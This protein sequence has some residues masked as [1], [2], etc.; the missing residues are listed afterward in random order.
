MWS[1]DITKLKGP[2]KW[3]YFYLYVILDIFS[4]YAVGWMVATKESAA[5]A[6]Q[7]IKE[8]VLKQGVA[9]G[10]LTIHSDRGSPMKAK[11]TALLMAD[12]G[13]TKSHS[14][15]YVSDDNPFSESQF[16]TVKYNPD[17]PGCFG[18]V[19]DARV[20]CGP[21]F[22][23]YNTEHR[24]SGIGMMTPE[25]VHYGLAEQV[26]AE[27]E[28]V[29]DAAYAAHPERFVRGRPTPPVLPQAVWINPPRATADDRAAARGEH[30]QPDRLDRAG[31]EALH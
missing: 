23:W 19:I 31:E 27:R 20:F 21:F 24:H 12:L 28:R 17:F 3:T 8:T 22:D 26:R 30:S 10:D 16:K 6:Q 1:W 5:L 15:P 4:R 9:P 29:L 25:M 14:R 18:S 13:I 2:A 11:S 7:L